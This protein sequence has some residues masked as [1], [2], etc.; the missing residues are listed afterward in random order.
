MVNNT[1]NN[2]HTLGSL[3]VNLSNIHLSV[4]DKKILD[5]G[6]T[7]IHTYRKFPISKF[8]DAQNMLIR[9]LKL[10]DYFQHETNKEYNPKI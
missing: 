8:Y 9:N 5:K 3:T 6:L 2:H 10:K 7:F 4:A 1:N